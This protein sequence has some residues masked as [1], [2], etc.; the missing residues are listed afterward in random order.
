MEKSVALRAYVHYTNDENIYSEIVTLLAPSTNCG[1]GS[2]AGYPYGK[3][4]VMGSMSVL[5]L[6]SSKAGF[7]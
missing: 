6:L 1:Y 5:V 7:H 4:L 2:A 3:I